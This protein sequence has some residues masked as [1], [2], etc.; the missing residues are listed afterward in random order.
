MG[1]RLAICADDDQVVIRLS[2]RGGG[3][4]K[5]TWQSGESIWSFTSAVKLQDSTLEKVEKEEEVLLGRHNLDGSS[6][7]DPLELSSAQD[8]AQGQSPLSGTRLGVPLSR[9]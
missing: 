2:D 9:L 5:G 8:W 6:I 4:T 7:A 3:F 1:I